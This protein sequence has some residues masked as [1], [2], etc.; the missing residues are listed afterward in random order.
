MLIHIKKLFIFNL[1][2][3]FLCYASYA[4]ENKILFKV[5]N[6]IVTTQDV[7]NEINYLSALNPEIQNLDE[8]IIIE[9]SKN[10]IIR[11]KIKRIELKKNFNKLEVDENY[12]NQVIKSTFSQKNIQN[13][14]D[15]NNFLSLKNIDTRNIKIKI[16]TDILWNQL[17]LNK[18]SK[19][20]KIDK[21][22]V[23]NEISKTSK[24]KKLFLLSE[25]L[26]NIE[27]NDNLEETYSLIK[28]TINQKGFNNAALIHSVS[29]TSKN[30]GELG[31]IN[32]S[33]LN[34]QIK[35][36][37]SKID[38]GQHTKPIFTPGGYL[39]LFI[40]DIKIQKIEINYDEEFERIIK[41][42]TNEQ[43]NQF[44][45]IYYNKIKKDIIIDGI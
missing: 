25:I 13:I 36:E 24:E 28:K 6:E 44:S 35:N 39:I 11:E 19:Q 26:F 14:N 1:F 38:I 3:Y 27:N 16:S 45:N 22:K 40:N 15:L 17:I 23:K 33:S 41:I 31:W 4:L 9:I 37:I 29:D 2:F 8:N 32:E 18:F 20:I 7:L 42:K 43:L 34:D 10:S 30:G 5:D 12:I 21:D